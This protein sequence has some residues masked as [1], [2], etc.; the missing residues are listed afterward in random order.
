MMTMKRARAKLLAVLATVTGF[1]DVSHAACVSNQALQP[2]AT[3]P[4]L[5]GRLVYHAYLAYGDG[6]SSLYLH[7]FAA[8]TTIKFNSALWNL[9]DP[10]NAQFSVDGKSLIFMAV[11]YGSWNVFAWTIGSTKPPLNLTGPLGGRNED[12]KLTFDGKRVAFKHEGDV[13]FLTLV[14]NGA[15]I[16]GAANYQSITS[17]GWITEESMPTTSPSAKYLL[18][19]IGAAASSIYRMNIHTGQSQLLTSTPAGAHDY[20]PVVRD[21]STYFFTRG[22]PVSGND[23]IMM[24]VPNLTGSTAKALALNDCNSNNSDAAPVDEDTLIFSSNRYDPPYGLL[25]GDIG[26]GKVWRLNPTL[27]NLNDG[28]QKLGANY[29]TAR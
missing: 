15:E 20:F 26:S 16:I 19:T 10:M 14:L 12:P 27:I 13:G 17:N 9:S 28:K 8:Q 2:A 18:Y 29:S 5:S 4:R 24:M 22:M 7:D 21:M 25:I 1:A 3:F 23:Q 11:Q 6:S